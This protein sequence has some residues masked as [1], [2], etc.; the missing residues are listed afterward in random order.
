MNE[1]TKLPDGLQLAVKL[2]AQIGNDD[3]DRA[4]AAVHAVMDHGQP[5]ELPDGLN[6]AVEMIGEYAESGTCCSRRPAVAI[7]AIRA[8]HAQRVTLQH[9]ACDM[10]QQIE[11]LR[12]AAESGGRRIA[13]LEAER[14]HTAAHVA[15]IARQLGDE[16]LQVDDIAVRVLGL[17]AERDALRAKLDGIEAQEPV[18]YVLRSAASRPQPSVVTHQ[19]Y[20]SVAI[21]DRVD[22]GLEHLD[23]LY[24]RPV[25]AQAAPD[26]WRLV[27]ADPTEKMIGEGACASCLPGPHYIG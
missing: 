9:N 6:I 27:P 12:F 17:V 24:A 25:T 23:P 5:G 1:E 3:S 16:S 14:D 19:R 11:D 4:I 18:M 2:L 7:D 10:A 15:S 22:E 8:E 26:G 13:E 20:L 21:S